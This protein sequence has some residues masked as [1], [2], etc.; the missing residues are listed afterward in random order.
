MT[1]YPPFELFLNRQANLFLRLL[2]GINLN[3]VTNAF[4]GNRRE[5]IDGVR[6]LIAPHLNLTVEFPLKEILRG[7]S[8]AMVPVTLAQSTER[9]RQAEDQ[10][11]GQS[12]SF[13]LP[14]CLAGKI[15]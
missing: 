5:V 1:D 3:D 7:Y 9:R 6:P 4:K 11:N 15:L 2:F 10:G 8:W 14:L 13:H 12:L